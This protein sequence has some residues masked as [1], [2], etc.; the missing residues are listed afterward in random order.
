MLSGGKGETNFVLRA[1]EKKFWGGTKM[2]HE[3]SRSVVNKESKNG[4]V[5]IVTI[6]FAKMEFCILQT[7]DME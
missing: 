1:G 2:I 3:Q 6:E 5:K 7:K 4:R